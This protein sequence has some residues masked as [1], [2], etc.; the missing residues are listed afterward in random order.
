MA[1]LRSTQ[2]INWGG[3][4]PFVKNFV[5]IE[6]T[7]IAKTDTEVFYMIKDSV[8]GENE[9]LG[10]NNETLI[11]EYVL[12]TIRERRFSVPM[13]LYNQLY[14]AVEQQ[15]PAE[16]TAFEKEQ[17]RPK[18]A[19]LIYFQ[20]DKIIDENNNEFCLYGTQSNQWQIV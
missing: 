20:N 6:A 15:M 7:E 1:K 18:M 11:S 5:E 8:I 19:L 13:A 9:Y 14:N 2:K 17:I 4:N 16:L 3:W 12:Q 10:E